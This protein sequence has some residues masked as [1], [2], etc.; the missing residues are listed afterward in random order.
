MSGKPYMLYNCSS[1]YGKEN[2]ACKL[3]VGLLETLKNDMEKYGKLV[4][5]LPDQNSYLHK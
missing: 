4:P 2:F 3:D 5:L 1:K